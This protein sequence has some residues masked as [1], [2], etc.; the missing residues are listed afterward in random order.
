MLGL[1]SEAR[2]VRGRVPKSVRDF[3]DILSVGSVHERDC[4]EEGVDLLQGRWRRSNRDERGQ[5]VIGDLAIV[6]L[7]SADV[8][9]D[10]VVFGEIVVDD[11]SVGEMRKVGLE[12]RKNGR[13]YENK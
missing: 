8:E 6:S 3:V 4:R 5:V 1:L 11:P 7:G 2:A 13:G 10:V 9:L 12:V